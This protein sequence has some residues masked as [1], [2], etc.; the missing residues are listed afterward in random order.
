MAIND[1]NILH[2]LMCIYRA[3]NMDDA[4]MLREAAFKDDFVSMKAILEDNI[5]TSKS[6]ADKLWNSVRYTYFYGYCKKYHK[7]ICFLE[8]IGEKID[9]K[10]RDV[11]IGAIKAQKEL[12]KLLISQGFD[13]AQL[14]NYLDGK[15]DVEF[16]LDEATKSTGLLRRMIDRRLVG[17]IDASPAG[18]LNH[19]NGLI[20]STESNLSAQDVETDTPV[21]ESE[22]DFI[23]SSI[24]WQ[25]SD[26]KGNMS[27]SDYKKLVSAFIKYYEDGEFPTFDKMIQIRGRVPKKLFGWHI[28]RICEVM[29]EGI[30]KEL[31]FFAQQNISLY[32]NDPINE[33]NF[34]KCNL[35]KYFTSKAL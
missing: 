33:N 35:Y 20:V 15:E 8:L 5:R 25:L 4:K 34:R 30:E 28:N 21:E 22:S 18:S 27:E 13:L 11:V 26:F 23:L 2:K 24:E 14:E 10:E 17:S 12:V 16:V 7:G 19:S 9:C 6:N 1:K 32:R 3:K 31:L 29:G